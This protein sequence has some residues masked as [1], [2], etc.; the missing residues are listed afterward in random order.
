[1]PN[2][3]LITKIAASFL[4]VALIVFSLSG[5]VPAAVGVG[6]A[7]IAASSTEK[8]LGTSISD[9]IIKVKIRDNFLKQN[10]DILQSVSISSNQGS[11]LLTGVVD[12]PETRV[13]ASQLAWEVSGVNEVINEITIKDTSSFKD[14]AKDKAAEAELRAK[15]IGDGEISSLNFSIDVVNG[16]VFITGLASTEEELQAV[17]AHAREIRFAKEVV[18][19]ARVNDD[20]RQ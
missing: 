1:M 18:N 17:I 13:Q 19:Y 3:Q 5:C 4:T 16:K 8:G 11:V 7:A 12:E 10:V 15:L 6:T 2:L 20:T 9:G 14:F